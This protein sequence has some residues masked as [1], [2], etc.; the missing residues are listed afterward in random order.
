MHKSQILVMAYYLPM[1]LHD[2]NLKLKLG[3][4]YDEQIWS[5]FGHQLGHMKFYKDAF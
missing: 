5:I 1:P 4:L 3:I 2:M